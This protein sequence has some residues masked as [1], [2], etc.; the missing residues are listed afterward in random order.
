M[1]PIGQFCRRIFV[2]QSDKQ[3]ISN[4]D[5]NGELERAGYHY[6][7]LHQP[8][9]WNDVHSWCQE[10][11]GEEHYSWTG[12]KFWFDDPK[13]ATLFSLRWN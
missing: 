8:G 4:I 1:I 5:W 2:E 12:S 13:N 7:Y 3:M 11:F 6:V 9:S 10:Q